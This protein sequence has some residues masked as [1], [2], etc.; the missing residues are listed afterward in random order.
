MWVNHVD[1]D[2]R[3]TATP[4]T[5]RTKELTAIQKITAANKLNT[6]AKKATKI[7]TA[8]F[9]TTK[10]S[11]SRN[12]YMNSFCTVSVLGYSTNTKYLQ[13]CI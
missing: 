3:A 9:L 1:R 5:K 8:N 10:Y 11:S 4:N 12:E 6:L 13:V 7:T 2:Q